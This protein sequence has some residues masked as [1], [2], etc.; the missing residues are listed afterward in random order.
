MRLQWWDFACGLTGPLGLRSG[1]NRNTAGMEMC[2]FSI[3]VSQ[4]LPEMIASNHCLRTMCAVV[5]SVSQR[6]CLGLSAY[7]SM[8]RW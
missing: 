6:K 3:L 5:D 4:L 8:H 1:P 2:V 7:L